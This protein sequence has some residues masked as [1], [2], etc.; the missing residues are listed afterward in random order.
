MSTDM[1]PEEAPRDECRSQGG[2]MTD[3]EQYP[4]G[5]IR[6]EHPLYMIFEVIHVKRKTPFDFRE[7]Q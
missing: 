1:V 4:E 3:M 2:E 6:E 5:P 7:E